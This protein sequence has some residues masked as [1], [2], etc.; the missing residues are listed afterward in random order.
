[1]P[2]F[3]TKI[4]LHSDDYQKNAER[5]SGLVGNLNE[6]IYKMYKPITLIFLLIGIISVLV[7]SSVAFNEIASL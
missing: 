4:D 5:M 6:K 3:K 1:M 7:L 2:V